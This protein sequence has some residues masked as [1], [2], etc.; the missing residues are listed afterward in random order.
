MSV[1]IKIIQRQGN[2]AQVLRTFGVKVPLVYLNNTRTV[3]GAFLKLYD[4]T[5]TPNVGVDVPVFTV[6]VVAAPST[7]NPGANAFQT[8]DP[9]QFVNG[10]AIAIT[11][12]SLDTDNTTL[13][14]DNLVSGVILVDK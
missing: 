6:A 5:T 13:P 14:N 11:A 12:G 2:S 7:T 3:V 8:S 9:I 1:P 4:Q 10:L